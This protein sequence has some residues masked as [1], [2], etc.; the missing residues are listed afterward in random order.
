MWHKVRKVKLGRTQAERKALLL[1]LSKSLIT[2]GNIVTTL[3]KA[4]F[5]RP[6]IEKYITRAIQNSLHARRLLLKDLRDKKVVKHLMDDVGPVFKSR[7]GGYT[8][9]QRL[10]RRVGDNAMLVK[11]SLVETVDTQK[12]K[13]ALVEEKPKTVRT[14]A[15]K[16]ATE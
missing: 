7:K 5:A 3:E 1:N 10:K 2:K 16:T 6:P 15:K 8:R 9:I 13:K 14:R 4:K 12:P 11:F